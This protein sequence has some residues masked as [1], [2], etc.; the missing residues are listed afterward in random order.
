M[1]LNYFRYQ[2][3]S[4]HALFVLTRRMLD[5]LDGAG[6][7]LVGSVGH[8]T[9]LFDAMD[10][11]PPST[12]AEIAGAAGLHERYVREWLAGMTVARVLE[13]DAGRGTYFLPPEHA[14]S[15]TRA[16]GVHNQAPILQYIA[17]MGQVEQQVVEAFRAGGG[18]PY[19]AY[20]RFQRLQAEES[21]RVYDAVLVDSIVPLA[22][23]LTERLEAGIDV[24]DV[25]TGQGRAVNV[26]AERFPRSRF[27]GIDTSEAGI[28]TARSEA[29][30]RELGNVRF[31]VADSA[32]LSG[33]YDRLSIRLIP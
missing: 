11:L 13:Y 5:V 12:S 28:F 14:A 18:V 23:G 26:L 29:G 17:M 32:Q 21:A 9:G 8:Q 27:R 19:S 2:P 22:Q 30:E 1:F 33:E 7:A 31:D 10:G 4:D 20:P 15:L 3:A 25:G 24:L 6:L 16:A